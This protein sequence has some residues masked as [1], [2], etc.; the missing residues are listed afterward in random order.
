MGLH[1]E[2]GDGE[3]Q[4]D[5]VELKALTAHFEKKKDKP[6]EAFADIIWAVINTKEFLFNH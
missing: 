1:H 4:A 2:V 3:P 6:Q 5:A